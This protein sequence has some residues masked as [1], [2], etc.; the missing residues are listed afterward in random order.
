MSATEYGHG[1]CSIEYLTCKPGGDG[2][3][4]N[5]SGGRVRIRSTMGGNTVGWLKPGMSVVVISWA[6]DQNG[7]EWAYTK[8]GWILG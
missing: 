5:V 7:S 3:W 6:K 4:C 2:V 1:F 8:Q